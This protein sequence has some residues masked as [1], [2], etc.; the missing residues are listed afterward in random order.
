MKARELFDII[1]K[2]FGLLV[3]KDF[4]TQL[5]LILNPIL[6]FIIRGSEAPEGLWMLALGIL[7]T[8]IYLAVAYQ[9]LFRTHAVMKFLKLGD[10]LG[11]ADLSIA[12][13]KRNILAIA[14]IATAGY[15]LIYDIPVFCSLIYNYFELKESG[16]LE[17][18]RTPVRDLVLS[19]ARIIIALLLIG[20]RKKIM[21]LLLR[22]NKG[23]AI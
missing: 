6:F 14:L 11:D 22:E 2:I 19:G 17:D 21:D 15:I 20:E 23:E 9:L 10:E 1:L 7:I 12:I 3:I 8:G 18:V 5:S 13:S 16:I 4:L